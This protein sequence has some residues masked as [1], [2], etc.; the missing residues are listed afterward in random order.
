MRK[1]IIAAALALGLSGCVLE[2]A[3]TGFV[4]GTAAYCAGVSEVGKQAIRDVVTAGKQ[5]IA[6]EA[7]DVE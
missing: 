3:T 1:T 2:I 5:V 4:V 6:C 7:P